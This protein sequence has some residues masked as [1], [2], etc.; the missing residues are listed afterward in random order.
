MGRAHNLHTG[1]IGCTT[2]NSITPVYNCRLFKWSAYFRELLK[3][4]SCSKTARMD[5]HHFPSD[6]K[7][8]LPCWETNVHVNRVKAHSLLCS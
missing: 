6:R 2:N 5:Y 8:F 1:C 7:P 4:S 3:C